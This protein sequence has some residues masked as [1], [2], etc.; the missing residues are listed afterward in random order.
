[1]GVPGIDDFKNYVE[2]FK[3]NNGKEDPDGGIFKDLRDL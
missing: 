2:E 1:L 3:N